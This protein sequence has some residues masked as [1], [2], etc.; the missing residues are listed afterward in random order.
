M[1]RILLVDDDAA[2]RQVIERLLTQKGHTVT[3]ATDGVKALRLLEASSFDLVISDVVM[4]DMEGLQ[5]LREIRKNP[6]PPGVIVISG[7][8]RGTAAEYLALATSFGAAA[9]LTKPFALDALTDAVER[10]LGTG[11]PRGS[12][13][14]P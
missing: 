5:L 6:S 2:V 4:P 1:P 13:Q 14:D 11:N 12:G 3:T 10:V 9:T 7:G 8:G